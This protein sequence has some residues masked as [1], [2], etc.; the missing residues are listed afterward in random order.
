MWKKA[1]WIGVPREEIEEKKI[2]QGD[3]NGR[4]AYYRLEIELEEAGEAI[5]D[6]SANSRY[7]L[8]INEK[9]VLSGPCRSNQFRHYYETVDLKPYLKKG[10]NIL[11]AQVLLYDSMYTAGWQDQRAPLVSVASLPAGHRFALEGAVKDAQGVDAAEL[12]TGKADWRVWLDNTFYLYKEGAVDTNLGALAEKI[13]FSRTPGNW[14]SES[15]DASGWKKAVELE[16]AAEGHEKFLG[17]LKTFR[18]EE[19]PIPL[20]VEEEA[21]LDKELGE[22]V[23]GE[24]EALTVEPGEKKVLLFD[25]KTLFNAYF[26]YHIQ[27]GKGAEISFTYFEKFTKGRDEVKRDDYRNG[28]IGNNG[29]TDR[30]FPAGGD[31]LYEPFWYHTMRFLKIE[32][33]AGE[34]AVKFYRPQLLKTGYPLRPESEISST[35]EWVQPIYEMCVRTLQDCMMETYMDCPFWEQMQYPMD[36]RL[37]ALFT[38]VC[39]TDTK[40][41]RKA[42]QD[43]HDS[44]LPMGLVQG[45]APSNPLQVISTFSLYYIFMLL[46]YYQRTGDLKV[47]KL[48]RSDVD[49]ILEYYDG[50]IGTSGLVENLGYWE[51]IDWQESWEKTCG[52]PVAAEEGP[53]TIINLMYGLALLKGAK[54][55]EITGREGLAEE[56]RKRQ[57]QI[58]EKVQK[59]CWDEERGLYR[60]GPSYR[61][62]SQHAQSWAVL[63]GLL[64]GE[65]ARAVMEKTFREPDVL[66]CYF[67]TCYELFR[68]CELAGC[69]ELTG[70]Q[71]DWWLKLLDEHCTTCPETPAGSRSECHAWSA[72]PMYEL[73]SVMAGIRRESGEPSNVVVKPH[74]NAVPDLRGKFATEYGSILFYYEKQEN[75]IR[76]SITLPAGMTGTFLYPDG[77]SFSLVAGKNRIG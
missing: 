62:F 12:T 23:L 71:M 60:E 3:M 31:L 46:E 27:G 72:L 21:T 17:I 77:T 50:K 49:G 51:F 4:F 32:I 73:M 8:W 15:F 30:I 6:L 33:Q 58:A 76:G 52:R 56:Y 70:E 14:K 24:K 25:G 28:E 35:A 22:P 34:E 41:A 74:L 19:R 11:A 20:C 53:S 69:Y 67:S 45:R 18:L 59:L 39:S 75:G 5:V 66:R 37:Q 2:Y 57:K 55:A 42:L 65:K 7:R 40:L 47:L 36:T 29:R 44:I 9:P 16:T 26:R 68:A 54:I 38:Y 64:K 13:D 61:Q 1:M 63:N 48:Y 10:K 43:F